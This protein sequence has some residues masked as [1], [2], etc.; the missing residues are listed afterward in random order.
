MK[1]E[2]SPAATPATPTLTGEA[3]ASAYIAQELPKARKALRRARIV[4]WV[5]IGLIGGYISIISV[6]LVRLFQPRTAAQV[7]SGMVLERVAKDGPALAVQLE[8]QIPL[9]IRQ[10]PDYVIQQ[11]PGY[12]QQAELVLETELQSH[13]DTLARQVGQQMDDQIANH[14]ADLKTLLDHPADRAAVRAILPDLDQTISSFLT[15]DADG[16]VVQEH[17]SDLAAGLK[18]IEKRM[19]RLANGTNLT[20]EEKKARRSLAVMAKAIK[21]KTTLPEPS[22]APVGK[23][24]SK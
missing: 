23:L 7:A 24:A 6:T 14:Q 12:R 18:E 10:A 15:M 21:D 8:R 22:A 3:A 5:L 16:K 17:I 20:P 19:D 9:L 2:S 13:C 11:L 1:P 4:G